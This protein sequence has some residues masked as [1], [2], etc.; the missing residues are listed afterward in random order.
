MQ[1]KACITW[2]SDHGHTIVG[3]E[4]DEGVSGTKDLDNRMALANSLA[5]VKS[6]R[7]EGIVAYRLD[8]WARD[9]ILQEHLLNE[10]R[11]MGGQL[12]TTSGAEAEY[13]EDDPKDHH[14]G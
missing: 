4:T 12:F 11:H 10:I 6:G 8:R 1:E 5:A 9:L 13:L 2:A 7:A 3:V 14:A